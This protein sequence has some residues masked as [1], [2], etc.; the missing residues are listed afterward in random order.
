MG[1]FPELYLVTSNFLSTRVLYLQH[2]NSLPR[3]FV[4]V[5]YHVYHVSRSPRKPASSR[6]GQFRVECRQGVGHQRI[7]GP[8]KVCEL[9]CTRLVCVL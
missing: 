1:S 5:L 2:S 6:Y 7:R 9:H 4:H 8:C 3:H